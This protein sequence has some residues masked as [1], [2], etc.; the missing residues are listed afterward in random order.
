M[1][2]PQ[3]V[4]SE[5]E[6]L[7]ANFAK[8]N[9]IEDSIKS[10]A[11]KGE[12][13]SEL[14][15]QVEKIGADNAAAVKAIEDTKAEMAERQD[16]FEIE[17]KK[18]FGFGGHGTTDPLNGFVKSYSDEGVS[19]KHGGR[20]WRHEIPVKTITNVAGS[21]GPLIRP[22]ERDGIIGPGEPQLTVLDLV[23]VIPTSASSIDFLR[24]L[25]VTNNA[26]YQTA[27][28]EKK[29]ETTFTFERANEVV[30]TIA[31]F[32]KASTQILDDATALEAY[33]RS[34]ML[35]LLRQKASSEILNGAGG[36]NA[37]NGIN[38]Q[39]DA[40]DTDLDPEDATKIDRLR[41]A[42]A[43]VYESEFPATAFVLNHMD[44]A[45]I[46]LTKEDGV[47]YVLANPANA[48]GPRLWGLPVAQDRAQAKGEFTVGSF[49]PAALHLWVRQQASIQLATENEDDFVKN[50]VTILAEMRAALTVYRPSAFVHGELVDSET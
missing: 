17:A 40:Y 27:H 5:L 42:V 8:I 47:G 41:M 18:S 34:R 31:H 21:A 39:A 3:A 45:E 44:W 25:A 4:K 48:T 36:A 46:E 9:E 38:E 49:T 24:E 14:K 11:A 30:R 15:A 12:A 22:Q 10:L 23:P 13:V 2:V 35:F 28:G 19:V 20:R 50:L 1:E 26:Q 37:I 33:V 43:Q 7:S 29:G 32:V 16:S 6:R